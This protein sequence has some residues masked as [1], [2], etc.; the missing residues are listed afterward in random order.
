MSSA[1]VF[2][3]KKLT[4][5]SRL[6][7]AAGFSIAVF[8]VCGAAPGLA[9]SFDLDKVMKAKVPGLQSE[10]RGA[11][12]FYGDCIQVTLSNNTGQPV[13]VD[14]PLGLLLLPGNPRVQ[15][16]VC[17][18]GESLDAPPGTTTHRI[19]A[20]CGEHSDSQPGTGDVFSPGGRASGD[21]LKRVKEIFNNQKFDS[22]TQHRIWEI[23]N[24]LDLSKGAGAPSSAEKKATAAA[25]LT[26]LIFIAWQLVNNFV[27]VPGVPVPV[28]EGG[29][30]EVP[31]PGGDETP[32]SGGGETEPESYDDR[33]AWSLVHRRSYDD[34]FD[35]KNERWVSRDSDEG[36]AILEKKKKMMEK[37]GF[38][39]DE[40][41]DAFIERGLVFDE[42]SRSYRR[43]LTKPAPADIKS[44]EGDA[45]RVYIGPGWLFTGDPGTSSDPEVVN[46]NLENRLKHLDELED[47]VE[48]EHE[49]L[50]DRLRD[51]ERQEGK[52]P[53]LEDQLK[54]QREELKQK[55]RNVQEQKLDLT[56]R[57]DQ[58]D[59]EYDTWTERQ[60]KSW[61]AKKVGKELSEVF[62][63]NAEDLKPLFEKTLELRNRLQKA[64][65]EQ[66]A[67]FR[68]VDGTM[69]RIKQI[70]ADM[71]EAQD[72]GDM[73]AV[74]SLQ[75]QMD[76][77]RAK[78]QG[79]NNEMQM[80]HKK[81]AQWQ[82]GSHALTITAGMTANQY[83]G[84]SRMVLEIGKRGAQFLKPQTGFRRP[85]IL[86]S[87]KG[88]Q[89][90]REFYAVDKD[91]NIREI[92]GADAVDYKPQKGELVVGRDPDS[93]KLTE[94]EF[95]GGGRG[96]PLTDGQKNLLRRQAEKGLADKPLRP[97]ETGRKYAGP[98]GV[99][100]AEDGSLTYAPAEER[101]GTP[102]AQKQ[103][104]LPKDL[105]ELKDMV[106]KEQL[107]EAV[108]NKPG[109]GQ[110]KSAEAEKIADRLTRGERPSYSRRD[111]P[112]SEKEWLERDKALHPGQEPKMKKMGEILG[113]YPDERAKEMASRNP[114][115]A[116][117]DKAVR[118]AFDESGVMADDVANPEPG[119]R[120]MELATKKGV[121]PQDWK[122]WQKAMD[123][124]EWHPIQENR[125]ATVK[126]KIG[127]KPAPGSMPAGKTVAGEVQAAPPEE[128]PMAS[129][130]PPKSSMPQD[131]SRPGATAQP[132]TPSQPPAASQP[133]APSPAPS[134]APRPA[135]APRVS[136]PPESP[137]PT[138]AI[139]EPSPT[140]QEPH[141]AAS[142]TASPG[143][144]KE[145]L[146]ESDRSFDARATTLESAAELKE[147]KLDGA[148]D[149]ESASDMK[150]LSSSLS[151]REVSAAGGL[152]T[153]GLEKEIPLQEK[154]LSFARMLQGILR[155]PK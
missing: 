2:A 144:G 7:I 143:I 85:T 42:H 63:P 103:V 139:P 21:L 29:G 45:S 49:A 50:S 112:L 128:M 129:F 138:A 86:E 67:L 80:I 121:R 113:V 84:Q 97:L 9:T 137:A 73:N 64:I 5:S 48:S 62:I 57:V 145:A 133:K 101:T 108:K 27:N 72:R 77:A 41:Q 61:T 76:A 100:T 11:G 147:M 59:R 6:F 19:K 1:L 53:W 99:T 155:K 110:Q 31:P 120:F 47:D 32:S 94:Q 75:G 116:R 83:V 8:L 26:V 40:D 79:L 132:Q 148:G 149:L 70:A 114:D 82:A 55:M 37:K 44:E 33:P 87:T 25:V 150:D 154:S 136:P 54:K 20:F 107:M 43:P 118:Q 39:Y 134:N 88:G 56:R 115:F 104:D 23:T 69:S 15:T 24:A 153:A 46:K 102:P 117:I 38:D 95:G 125:P 58:R 52:D 92:K 3:S 98:S 90:D 124:G 34:L 122:N 81:S 135:A 141:G 51:I 74:R 89:A 30:E 93:G 18:G 36:R 65:N 71:K 22:S 4:L 130:E 16:M 35:D 91:G 109:V 126:V 111:V 131:V 60:K 13:T 140:I 119:E 105:R 66:P 68:E 96:Q 14:V 10:V 151:S 123:E 12:G 17:A 142:A 152:E 28:P 106:V 127:P 78:L 146:S